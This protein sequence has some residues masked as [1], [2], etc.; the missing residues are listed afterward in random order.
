[1]LED[2]K[3]AFLKTLFSCAATNMPHYL[4]STC[5]FWSKAVIKLLTAWDMLEK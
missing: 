2:K 5:V 4:A 3:A 1:M